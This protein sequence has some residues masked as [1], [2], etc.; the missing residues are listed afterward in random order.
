MNATKV[1]SV[2][3]IYFGKLDAYSEF[4]EYGKDTYQSL[5]YACP[6]FHVEK[7]LD[8]KAYYI[9]GDKG[10][11][12]TALLKYLEITADS[13]N[14][15]VEYIRFKKDVD[16]EE[17]NSLKRAGI[18]N[19]T[20]EEVID[21]NIPTDTSIDC[22]YAWQVY[23]IKCIIN[24]IEAS[25]EKFFKET[26]TLKKLKKLIQSAYK[27]DTSLIKRII[28]KVKRGS[29][30]LD[31]T[32]SLEI[33]ADF[34]WDDENEKTVSFSNYAKTVIALFSDLERIGDKKCFVL[35][36]ELELIYFQRKKY[37]RDVALLRDLIQ[38]IYYINEITKKRK[39][40][41]FSIACIRN[42]VYH[43]IASVGYEINKI[44][45]D[46]GVEISWLQSGGSL[47][48][49]PLIQMLIK[50]LINSQPEYARNISDN[51]IW[52]AYFDEYININYLNQTSMSYVIDQT[53]NKP[54]DI[55]RLFNLI[56][57]KHE[58]A[59]KITTSCFES[60]RKTYSQESWEEFSNELSAKYSPEEIDGIKQVL[61]GIGTSFSLKNFSERIDEKA[62]HFPSVAQLKHNRSAAEILSDIYRIGIIG[63]ES[64]W[65][66]FYFKGDTD[67][68]STANCIIHYPLRRF[69]SVQTDILS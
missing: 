16:E 34:E 11:G 29:V 63:T 42:E 54:R 8:G 68:D 14:A 67:F 17:R 65:K 69:F 60:V 20:F 51:E 12:K 53:W 39:Y 23:I 59:T 41:I 64:K 66:R 1:V 27:N 26:S 56:Q 9:Y 3:D 25:G 58:N 36:D 47:K 40:C 32:D 31:I 13:Q 43:S 37:L 50:R 44:I 15:L 28:P 61:V 48:D 49:S 22:I 21:E 24:R 30:R 10:T 45:Q 2:G 52:T 62:P 57:K 5:F 4:L 35:F 19:N 55:I 33:G 18:A 6:S 46:Y 38:A 7:F